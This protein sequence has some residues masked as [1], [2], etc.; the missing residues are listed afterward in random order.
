VILAIG[1]AAGGS[2][3]LARPSSM[4]PIVAPPSVAVSATAPIEVAALF[5]T[6]KSVDKGSAEIALTFQ[7]GLG[8]ATLLERAGIAHADAADAERLV[9]AH[10]PDG[11]PEDTEVA[12]LLGSVG[13]HGSYRLDGLR[14]QTPTHVE[15]SLS[16]AS[17]GVLQLSRSKPAGIKADRFAGEI[18]T[19]LYWSLRQAGLSAELSNEFVAALREQ[20][21]R[22]QFE[23]VVVNGRRANGAQ[24]APV[25]LY[26]AVK[27]GQRSERRVKWTVGTETQWIDPGGP[28]AR[29]SAM[30]VPVRGR[31]TSQ[32][33]SRAHPILRLFR[34]H[35][36]VDIAAPSGTPIL[37]AADGRVIADGWNGGH[38]Q[39]VRILHHNGLETSYSHM[40]AIAAHAGTS[41]RKGQVIGYVGSSGLS[42]GPHLHFEV[43]RGGQPIDPLAANMDAP[44]Q[45]D[46]R[47]RGE[48]A[49]HVKQLLA[50]ATLRRA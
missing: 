40:S 23:A 27:G 44:G 10:M 7:Q 49:R 26:A 8:L 15:L 42:T 17:S 29:S 19:S 16:R 14:L 5:G 36:G 2:A 6:E 31:I 25:L 45:L 24:A 30:L 4:E 18:G 38:G 43:R 11:V 47:Q 13:K 3:L 37:A 33:G 28:I 22:G 41:V 35:R 32:F 50:V 48:I 21:R 9:R 12:I 34:F 1:A 39:Q 20:H 46:S